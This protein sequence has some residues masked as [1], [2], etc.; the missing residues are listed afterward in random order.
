M[1]ITLSKFYSTKKNQGRWIESECYYNACYNRVNAFKG[2]GLKMVIGSLGLNS[3]F[4]YGGRNWTMK[5]FKQNPRDSH[6]WL[7]DAEGNVYDY[8]YEVYAYCA[9]TW[10]KKV[11]FP[12]NWEIIG[13]SKKAL[14]EEYGL[15]YVPAEK[16]VQMMILNYVVENVYEPRMRY[17]GLSRVPMTLQ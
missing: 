12:T 1:G 8:I 13:I 7:E 6:A 14:K 2:L 5:Q 4:E 17:G 15:E 10:G 3:H 16:V 11:S 9:K